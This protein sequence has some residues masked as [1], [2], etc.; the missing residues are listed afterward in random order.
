MDPIS[1]VCIAS[2]VGVSA[3]VGAKH[4]DIGVAI[5]KRIERRVQPNERLIV[6]LALSTDPTKV[7]KIDL[8]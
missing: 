2:A 6:N 4:H 7:V 3:Y 8:K 1:I 5:H